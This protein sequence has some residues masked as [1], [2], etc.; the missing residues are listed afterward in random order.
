[1]E[2]TDHNKLLAKHV[3]Y[4]EKLKTQREELLG[5]LASNHYAW[6]SKR[7]DWATKKRIENLKKHGI[8]VRQMQILLDIRSKITGVKMI[9]LGL[10]P[11]VITD[12]DAK[13]VESTLTHEAIHVKQYTENAPKDVLSARIGFIKFWMQEQ[14][15]IIK[16]LKKQRQKY[17]TNAARRYAI[18]NS[19]MEFEAYMHEGDIW[20]IETRVPFAYK[21]YET[22]VGRSAAI[23]A[24][25]TED[26]VQRRDKVKALEDMVTKQK[27]SNEE[28]V[29]I[30]HTLIDELVQDA[31]KIQQIQKEYG[32]GDRELISSSKRPKWPIVRLESEKNKEE[33]VGNPG[34][35]I[36]QG[37]C[38]T[39][40]NLYI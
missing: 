34:Q 36:G 14:W 33:K 24:K 3:Q 4:D 12:K 16:K 28:E 27:E 26:I 20:Y 2:K 10:G 18:N 29:A 7:Y 23:Q 31:Q 15:K 38:F 25:M 39:Q 1:M 37:T 30:L 22:K 6:Y 5:N 19:P 9:W 35:I 8:K 13:D 17:G 11:L 40:R 21:Q 32:K